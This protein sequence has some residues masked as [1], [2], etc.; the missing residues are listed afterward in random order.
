MAR[1][2]ACASA[3]RLRLA[4]W[5]R[6]VPG[7]SPLTLEALDLLEDAHDLENAREV[8]AHFLGALYEE[9]PVGVV[10]PH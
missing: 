4:N 6:S 1:L 5:V 7:V 3:E 9:L 8:V 2:N 10:G